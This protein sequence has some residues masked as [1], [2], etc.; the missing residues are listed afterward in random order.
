MIIDYSSGSTQVDDHEEECMF[1]DTAAPTLDVSLK[2]AR[3][4]IFPLPN[5]GYGCG[6]TH[7]CFQREHDLQS[8]VDNAAAIDN[9]H[10][11]VSR[12]SQG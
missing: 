11:D 3:N 6:S 1:V 8:V 9:A 10:A 5:C 2:N 4:Q 12:L 7:R